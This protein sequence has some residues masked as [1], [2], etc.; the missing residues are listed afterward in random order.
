[1][2]AGE[3]VWTPFKDDLS[4]IEMGF[5]RDVNKEPT[6]WRPAFVEEVGVQVRLP[7]LEPGVWSVW[8]RSRGVAERRGSVT[9]E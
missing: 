3:W 9:V 1:M 5:N 4:R 8:V 7:D 2:R 6:E